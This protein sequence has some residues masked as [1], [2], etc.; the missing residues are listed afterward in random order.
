[1]QE[2]FIDDLEENYI[3]PGN[4]TEDVILVKNQ[5]VYL[6]KLHNVE[7]IEGEQR[8]MMYAI[9]I[10]VRNRWD[11]DVLYAKRFKASAIQITEWMHELPPTTTTD[12]GD[13]HKD[14]HFL[15]NCNPAIMVGRIKIKPTASPPPTNDDPYDVMI[16][17]RSQSHP[18][19]TTRDCRVFTIRHG[20]GE[21][22]PLLYMNRKGFIYFPRMPSMLMIRVTVLNEMAPRWAS[23]DIEY[24]KIVSISVELKSYSQEWFVS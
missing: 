19:L 15:V 24:E 18:D 10:H 22:A 8:Q 13:T 2:A 3:L 14:L 21:E 20:A 1:M 9:A 17:V 23:I 16:E 6:V 7:N 11:W 5:N 12:N 4:Y